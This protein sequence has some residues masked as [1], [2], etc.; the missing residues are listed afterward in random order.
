MRPSGLVTNPALA[1]LW[2]G[3]LLVAARTSQDLFLAAKDLSFAATVTRS[4]VSRSA[5]LA[6]R[7]SAITSGTGAAWPLRPGVDDRAREATASVIERRRVAVPDR[8]ARE[9][10]LP[11]RERGRIAA[12]KRLPGETFVLCSHGPYFLGRTWRLSCFGWRH[13]LLVETEPA[14]ASWVASRLRR[15]RLSQRRSKSTVGFNSGMG[16]WHARRHRP[17]GGRGGSPGDGETLANR[18]ASPVPRRIMNRF[19]KGA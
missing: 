2:S 8:A 6:S 7:R 1:A 17:R 18:K 19:E 11:I 14:P 12:R 15:T 16:E 10:A 5:R 4:G 13:S 9:P 3:Y